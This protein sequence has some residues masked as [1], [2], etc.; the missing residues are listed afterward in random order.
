MQHKL[1]HANDDGH[2]DVLFFCG[3][4]FSYAPQRSCTNN[5]EKN[6]KLRLQLE[7]A[8]KMG[9]FKTEKAWSD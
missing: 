3:P 6:R 7:Q 9:N 4:V 8:A 1:N 5:S 2:D